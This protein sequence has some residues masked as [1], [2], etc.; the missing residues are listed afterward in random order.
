MT[1]RSSPS[2]S[3]AVS[4]ISLCAVNKTKGI[5]MSSSKMLRSELQNRKMEKEVLP[6]GHR[7]TA[8]TVTSLPNFSFGEHCTVSL[9]LN[10]RHEE[11]ECLSQFC[12][13]ITLGIGD[14][15]NSSSRKCQHL[16]LYPV[17]TQVYVSLQFGVFDI[18]YSYF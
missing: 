13:S 9:I 14:V 10:W 11:N 2:I 8:V 4:D 17:K 6:S 1:P 3:R 5:L 16:A 18:Q 12:G 7:A 15:I